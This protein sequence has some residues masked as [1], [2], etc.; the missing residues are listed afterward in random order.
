MYL[1]KEEEEILSGE[2]GPEYQKAMKALV[3]LGEAMG[4]KRLVSISHAHISGIS[5]R[6][7]GDAGLEFIE[8]LSKVK[9]K[10]FSTCN[11]AGFD[12]EFWKFLSIPRDFFVKQLRIINA[13]SKMGVKTACTCTPYYIREPSFGEHLAWGESS[14]VLYANTV[15]GARTNREG[16]PSSLFAALIGKT[17]YMG[18]HLSENRKPKIMINVEVGVEEQAYASTLGFVIGEVAKNRI[19]YIKI[20]FSSRNK[21]DLVKALCAGVGTSSSLPMCIIEGVSPEAKSTDLSSVEEKIRIEKRDLEKYFTKYSCNENFDAIFLGCPHLSLDE[22]VSVRKIV[23]K[24][25]RKVKYP[26]FLAV[27]RQIYSRI[28]YSILEEFKKYGIAVLRDTCLVV[29]PLNKMK[30]SSVATN[31][32]KHA[33]YLENIHGVKVRLCKTSE[34]LKIA[35]GVNL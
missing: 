29:A 33:Y 19:P 12:L 22:V 35:L 3:K 30:I 1:T 13:L 15:Y 27:S 23:S 32:I 8:E 25:K 6:N 21:L 4:A 9:V 10:V 28:P 20:R 2:Y 17:P 14:A 7:I 18:M 26:V 34:C 5:Y 24:E 31:S 16:G 11:P